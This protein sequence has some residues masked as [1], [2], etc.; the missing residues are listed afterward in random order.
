MN[1]KELFTVRFQFVQFGFHLSA[2]IFQLENIQGEFF[3]FLHHFLLHV[4]NHQAIVFY[5]LRGRNIGQVL[6]RPDVLTQILE[7]GELIVMRKNIIRPI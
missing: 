7:R 1:E 5:L 2:L 4:S 6:I 3:D